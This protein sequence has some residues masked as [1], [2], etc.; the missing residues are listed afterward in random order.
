MI[1]ITLLIHGE[2]RIIEWVWSWSEMGLVIN[3]LNNMENW[4][5]T[6]CIR[7]VASDTCYYYTNQNSRAHRDT[8][9]SIIIRCVHFKQLVPRVKSLAFLWSIFL[10]HFRRPVKFEKYMYLLYCRVLFWHFLHFTRE[11]TLPTRPP[12]FRA[13]PETFF[14]TNSYHRAYQVTIFASHF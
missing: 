9:H 5:I 1:Y 14:L 3:T 7:V 12:L 8:F 10:L 13:N 2:M 4:K 11:L 6:S